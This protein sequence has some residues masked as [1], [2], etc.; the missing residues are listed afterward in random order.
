M[1]CAI[2]SPLTAQTIDTLQIQNPPLVLP[3]AQVAN[4]YV[5]LKLGEF[6]K[7]KY[8]DCMDIA[9]TLNEMIQKQKEDAR[10]ASLK[11]GRLNMEIS[12]S[13]SENLEKA[14]EIQQLKDKKT[15]W[16]RHPILYAVLGIGFG[17]Y[18]SK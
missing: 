5:G 14:V 8:G 11:L 1:L 17:A 15:P 3:P 10:T 18:I 4:V 9:K 12:E 2:I 7:T 16:Y 6:Y 13:Q